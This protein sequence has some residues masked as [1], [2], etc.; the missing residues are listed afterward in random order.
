MPTTSRNIYCNW[1]VNALRALGPTKPAAVY[2]WIRRN[3]TVPAADLTGTTNDGENIFEKN[4]RW[5][6]FQLRHEGIVTS[7]TRGIWALAK[8]AP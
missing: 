3:E 4:V 2:D 1:V 8:A 6:R 5:A 7:P